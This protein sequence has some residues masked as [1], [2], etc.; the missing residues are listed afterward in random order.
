MAGDKPM[1][2]DNGL[3]APEA[4]RA[5][6]ESL[7][8][9]LDANQSV[10]MM[11]HTPEVCTVYLGDPSGPQEDLRRVGSVSTVLANEMLSLTSSGT[12]RIQIGDQLYRFVRSFTQ[13]GE[14]AAVVFSV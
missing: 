12:N 6:A 1:T 8:R 11:R 10:L 5:L 2:G 14:K 4:L 13:V 7:E 3:Q 9:A